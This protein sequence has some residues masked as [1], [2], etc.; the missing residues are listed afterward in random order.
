MKSLLWKGKMK[1]LF[2]RQKE[3]GFLQGGKA[4]FYRP[5]HGSDFQGKCP[6][7]YLQPRKKDL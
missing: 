7:L 3:E 5:V 1:S 4:L 2:L 6:G